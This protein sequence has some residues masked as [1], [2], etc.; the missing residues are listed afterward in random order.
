MPKYEVMTPDDFRA[1]FK[2][3]SP[4]QATRL[5]HKIMTNPDSPEKNVR[6]AR[7]YL[8]AYPG[9]YDP[10]AIKNNRVGRKYESGKTEYGPIKEKTLEQIA[11]T[12]AK[13]NPEQAQK[14]YE[15]SMHNLATP[16]ANRALMTMYRN[17]N[18]DKFNVEAYRQGNY[19]KNKPGTGKYWGGWGKKKTNTVNRTGQVLSIEDLQRSLN[20][21]GVPHR[22]RAYL[23]SIVLN[24]DSDPI[25][26]ANA[27]AILAQTNGFGLTDDQMRIW[28]ETHGRNADSAVKK[29]FFWSRFFK[30]KTEYDKMSPE[31]KRIFS[32]AYAKQDQNANAQYALKYFA[33]PNS[34][35]Q[36]IDAARSVVQQNPGMFFDNPNFKGQRK[37]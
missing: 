22:K 21:M 12:F 18:P 13:M 6:M 3:L 11:A 23:D 25:T 34:T 24:P 19:N 4:K 20:S 14:Y 2:N 10:S 16:M 28:G 8:K 1:R 27:R 9:Q 7:A 29:R 31:E 33:N 15:T 37:Q 26:V 5:A 32:T 35:Q 36:E 17:Q 30:T